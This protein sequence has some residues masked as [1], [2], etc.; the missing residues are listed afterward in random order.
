VEKTVAKLRNPALLFRIIAAQD[1]SSFAG[2]DPGHC[3]PIEKTTASQKTALKIGQKTGAGVL[4]T[5][6]IVLL[7]LAF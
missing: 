7:A 5:R 6:P 2:S 1:P 4:W 3:W